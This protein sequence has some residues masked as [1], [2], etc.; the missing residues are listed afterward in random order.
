VSVLPRPAALRSRPF[1]RLWAGS[2]V[3]STGTQMN[4]VAAAWLLYRSTHSTVPLGIQGLCFSVP[5]AVVPFV[6]GP[7][8]DR[9]DRATVVKVALVVEAA[10]AAGLAVLAWAGALQPWMFYLAAGVDAGRLAFVIPAQTALTP[11]LVPGE[12]LLSAQSLSMAVWSSSA[13]VGPAV[14]GLVLARYGAG[15][16]FA[17]NALATA[18][19]LAAVAGLRVPAAGG[20]PAARLMDGIRHVAAHRWVLAL[21]L[22]L[23]CTGTL[24]IG[25]ETVLPALAVQRWQASSVGYGMLRAAP[26]IAALL[27]GLSMSMLSRTP[28]RPLAIVGLGVLVSG[29]GVAAFA[30]AP[31]IVAA[32]GMLAATSVALTG[33]QIVAGTY[34]QRRMPRRFLGTLGGLNAISQSGASG[35]AAAGTAAAAQS[36]GPAAALTGAVLLLVP[37]TAVAVG[38]VAR[39]EVSGRP[40]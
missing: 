21:Q 7:V 14:G 39:G 29:A 27:A 24:A 13:L 17:A 36:A 37:A 3:S 15:A 6:A 8:V 2:L 28:R 23:V 5:I 25:T 16:V 34:L 38:A 1:A 11:L 35:I 18:V 10:T 12:L 30:R 4:I 22:V 40:E 33:T 32:W 26:G 20:P 31:R 19:A 9:L